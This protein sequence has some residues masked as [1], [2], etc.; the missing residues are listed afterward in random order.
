MGVFGSWYDTPTPPQRK[1]KKVYRSKTPCA[2]AR[3]HGKEYMGML[4]QL[5]GQFGVSPKI[6]LKKDLFSGGARGPRGVYVHF[7]QSRYIFTI[8]YPF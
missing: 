7:M 3:C 5:V 8:F 4:G 6:Q 2:C 1:V